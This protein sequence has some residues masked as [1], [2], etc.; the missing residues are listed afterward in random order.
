MTRLLP[1]LFPPNDRV[2]LLLQTEPLSVTSTLLL[3]LL[4]CCPTVA[5]LSKTCPPL[6]ITKLLP[7]PSRPTTR[8][9]EK[10]LLQT[11][12]DPLTTTLLFRLVPW[13]PM[14]PPPSTNTPVF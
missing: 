5:L 14:S 12:P 1:A 6:L 7:E 9:V 3:L 8:P 4:A 2:P 11:D 13:S 10:L